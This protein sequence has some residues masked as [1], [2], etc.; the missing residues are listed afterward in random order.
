MKLTWVKILLLDDNL[1]LFFLCHKSNRFSTLEKL[2][3]SEHKGGILMTQQC[4]FFSLQLT[5]VLSPSPQHITE[6]KYKFVIHKDLLEGR[7]HP[8]AIFRNSGIGTDITC[9]ATLAYCEKGG[10]EKNIIWLLILI[11]H[12]MNGAHYILLL[13]YY[14]YDK[15]P[16]TLHCNPWIIQYQPFK[17]KQYILVC[18]MG[19]SATSLTL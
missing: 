14:H 9:K 3:G 11:K 12:R 17:V 19:L 16:F 7:A 15:F 8:F 6:I 2:S 1:L 10:I 13:L 4:V 5:F 18:Q